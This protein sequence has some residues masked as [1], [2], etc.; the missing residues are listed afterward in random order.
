MSRY[1]CD[2]E[3]SKAEAAAD[4][5]QRALSVAHL[6]PGNADA[7]VRCGHGRGTEPPGHWYETTDEQNLAMA[8]GADIIPCDSV[9]AQILREQLAATEGR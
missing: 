2:S 4:L 8:R 3:I 7:C 6:V 5:Q 1:S 9:G